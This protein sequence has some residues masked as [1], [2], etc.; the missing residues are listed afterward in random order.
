MK[1]LE[2]TITQLRQLPIVAKNI[3]SFTGDKKVFAFYAPMG[4]GKTTLIK[5]LCTCLGSEDK[6]SSPT[7]SI[8]NEY[9][10][11]TSP[12]SKIYHLDLYRLN[13]IQE[14]LN[15]GVEEYI[16]S[17][18]Y[19]F[20]EWPEV[21]ESLLPADVVNIKLTTDGNIRNVSIFIGQ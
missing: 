21:V 5:E 12:S 3:L 9:L 1:Q 8:V 4:T 13:N 19:C 7:Y 17:G 16:E 6:F 20:I 15:A 10:L 11:L 14:A 18:H 2:A